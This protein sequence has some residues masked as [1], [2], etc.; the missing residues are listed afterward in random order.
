MT[1]PP[2]LLVR[3][4]MPCWQK[5]GTHTVH[6][7]QIEHEGADHTFDVIYDAMRQAALACGFAPETVKE[8]F[9]E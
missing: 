1:T 7:V 8:Y 3:V 5:D 2:R 4:E 9:D 6:A